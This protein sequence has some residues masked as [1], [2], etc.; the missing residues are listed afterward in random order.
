MR[1]RKDRIAFRC[2]ECGRAI[3]CLDAL[4]TETHYLCPRCLA[5]A[6]RTRSP[7]AFRALRPK[8]SA[9]KAE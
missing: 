1:Q 5:G 7:I 6:I 3:D 2:N 4:F 8:A 9:E